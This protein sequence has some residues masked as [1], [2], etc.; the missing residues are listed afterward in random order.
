M[1]GLPCG[2]A[3]QAL[4]L[5]P[6]WVGEGTKAARTSNSIIPLMFRYLNRSGTPKPLTLRDR[7][8]SRVGACYFL[9]LVVPT[10]RREKPFW[11]IHFFSAA[12]A[13]WTA[14]CDSSRFFRAAISAR[15]NSA[16]R[17]VKPRRPNEAS[18]KSFCFSR[19]CMSPTEEWVLL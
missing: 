15:I 13:T 11:N 19:A 7:R 16:S 10:R 3:L 8:G 9:N 1:D 12:A 5:N 2:S 14:G 17:G 6:G 18:A 4:D